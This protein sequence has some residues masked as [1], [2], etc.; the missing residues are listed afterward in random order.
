[1]IF[2]WKRSF[3]ALV[4]KLDDEEI[5]SKRSD[6]VAKQEISNKEIFVT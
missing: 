3:I 2:D 4:E 5:I 6:A 1:M